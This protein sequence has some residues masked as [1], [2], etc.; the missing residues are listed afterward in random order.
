MAR[1]L[2]GAELA[3]FVK[4]RQAYQVRN[5]KQEHHIAPKLVILMAEHAGPVIQKYVDLKSGYADDIGVA[6][7]TIV[8]GE[9]AML[10]TID[11]LNHDNDVHGVVVQLPLDDASRTDEITARIAPEKDVDGLG[12]RAKFVSATAEAIDWLLAGYNV[13]LNGK[14]IAVVGRGRLVGA[15]LANLW[16]ERGYTV[17]ALDETSKNTDK[18]LRKSDEIVSGTG[19]PRLITAERIAKDAVVVDAG[20]ASENGMLVGDVDD[21]VRTRRDVII[22][23][24]VGGVGPMTVTVMFDHV[25]QSALRRAGKLSS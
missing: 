18:V 16:S 8:C 14:K 15:P 7:E 9:E 13:D 20:T 3:G 2:N 6:F 25:I 4:E 17:T 23:P 24:K 22:T 11:A 19:V 21:E 5:L 1:E 12:P 10:D